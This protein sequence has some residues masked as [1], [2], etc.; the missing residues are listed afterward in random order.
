MPHPSVKV[1]LAVRRKTRSDGAMDTAADLIDRLGLTPHPEGGWY[2][3]VWRAAA[4]FPDDRAAATSILYLLEQG[5]RSHWHRVDAEE[6]WL[7]QG[8]APLRLRTNDGSG[9]VE[10]LL[11]TGPGQFPQHLVRKDEWQSAEADAGWCLVACIVSPGF[12]FDGFDLA[13][14]DWEP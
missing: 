7:F 4:E 10:N 11:G 13:P 2:R 1:W 9:T 12:H 8:G 5:Q 14:P 3:E 6:L